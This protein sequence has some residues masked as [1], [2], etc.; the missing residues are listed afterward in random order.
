MNSGETARNVVKPAEI[1]SCIRQLCGR[2][3]SNRPVA[4]K[5]IEPMLASVRWPPLAGECTTSGVVRTKV[6]FAIDAFGQSYMRAE[7][8]AL[9]INLSSLSF[10][11]FCITRDE[12]ARS[13]ERTT[14]LKRTVHLI[15]I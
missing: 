4:M 6:Y 7:A 1:V 5:R 10:M 2:R 12:L 8:V 14:A 9:A 11:A 13:H 3:S 15:G